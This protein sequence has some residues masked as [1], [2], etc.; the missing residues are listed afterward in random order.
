MKSQDL[1]SLK[2]KMSYAAVMIGA[3]R[4]KLTADSVSVA[5]TAFGPMKSCFRHGLFE[6]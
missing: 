1:F 2:K 3:L 6:G 5:R 4:V